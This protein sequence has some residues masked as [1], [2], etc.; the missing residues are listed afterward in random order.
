MDIGTAKPS[1]AD[2][3]RVPHHLYDV[4]APDEE[5]DV[6][7]YRL[8]ART[9]VREIASRG[10]LPV[11]VGG[12]GLYLRTLSRGLFS[13][14]PAHPRI[15][16]AL[17]AFAEASPGALHRWCRRLDPETA[18]RL[19]P[20]D[21]V[22]LVRALEVVLLTGRK[23]SA[24][25][26][27]HGFS[28][29]LGELLFFVLDPGR[30][31]L[32]RRIDERARQM[33]AQGL[34]E[35]VRRLWQMGYGPDLRVLQSIGYRQAGEVLRNETTLEQAVQDLIR[36]TRRFAKRQLTWF[37]SEPGVIWVHPDVD[38]A[39]IETS[40]EEFLQGSPHC[41]SILVRR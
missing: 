7:R 6:A 18:G 8:L 22:R 17:E 39:Q 25:Q 1:A 30:E 4:V 23:I 3:A 41:N 37:R 28:E 31:E 38:R 35:E 9:A 20:N 27:R 36:A 10:R 11:V 13:G 2:R 19:H 16:R 15:R 33:F 29:R 40:I 12:S 14:P 26:S 24:H 32:A 5:F 34:T 21:T